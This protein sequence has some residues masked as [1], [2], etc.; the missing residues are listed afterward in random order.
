MLLLAN[1]LNIT[2]LVNRFSSISI[3]NKFDKHIRL[4]WSNIVTEI[5]C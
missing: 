2:M 5:S 1:P 4:S 3:V